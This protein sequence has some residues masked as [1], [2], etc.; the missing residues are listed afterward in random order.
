MSVTANHPTPFAPFTLRLPEAAQIP[1]VCDSPH[2]GVKYPTDF[3]FSIPFNILRLGEDTHIETLWKNIPQAGGTLLAAEFPRSYIDPNRE[4]D[5]IDI[6]MLGAPW[7]HKAKPSEK[8]RIGSG[9]IWKYVGT[10]QDHMLIYDRLLTPTELQ[11]RIDNYY[12]PYHASLDEQIN[13]AYQKFGAYWHLNLHSM[14]TNTYESLGL[15]SPHP[16]AD[17]VLGNRDGKTCSAEFIQMVAS[18]L[19]DK[20][21]TV[22]LNDPYKGVAL[23]ERLGNPAQNRHSLQIE[24][25]RNLYMNETTREPHQGFEE[26]QKNLTALSNEIAAYIKEKLKS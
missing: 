25:H 26:L 21:Y 17:F 4:I 2:S 13:R 20:G 14:P 12:L 24:I 19:Q 3:N 16:L 15:T 8:S 18:S 6:A 9:L 5:D 1:L 11:A 7:P 10:P 22:A 23:I